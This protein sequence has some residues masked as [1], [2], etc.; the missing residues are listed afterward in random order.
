MTA[1]SDILLTQFRTRG[2]LTNGEVQAVI[3]NYDADL[4][5]SA[6]VAC[7]KLGDAVVLR[8]RNG[9]GF[10]W[11]LSL[12]DTLLQRH[13]GFDVSKLPQA[14]RIFLR[15]QGERL[16]LAID[17]KAGAIRKIVN[18]T[19][20][21]VLADALPRP[22]NAF[23]LAELYSEAAADMQ[24]LLANGKAVAIGL[25]VWASQAPTGATP[26]DARAEWI[27]LLSQRR[28]CV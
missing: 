8:S 20:Q 26:A 12:E 11:I 7:D 15:E 19:V 28:K 16:G 3:N 2:P 25:D 9:G 5:L 24:A 10:E 13:S 4:R 22:V 14:E 27:M 18:K 6:A 21:T 1:L 17:L 23:K